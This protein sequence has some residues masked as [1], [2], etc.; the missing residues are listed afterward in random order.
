MRLIHLAAFASLAALAA[1]SDAPVTQSEARDPFDMSQVKLL[2]P[3]QYA[4]HGIAT[5]PASQSPSFLIDGPCQVDDPTSCGGGGEP[6][7]PPEADV[8]FWGGVF[9]ESNYAGKQVRLHAKSDAHNNMD[10][11]VLS[12]SFRSVGGQYGCS[13]TPA[14]FTSDYKV[15]YGAP[16]HVESERY[17]SYASSMTFIW[18]VKSSHSFTAN[19]GYVLPN[20]RRSY[21]FGSGGRLCV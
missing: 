12:V 14:Q 17:A 6:Y 16:V 8:D 2:T 21:T 18:E 7:T 5:L 1:C 15:A 10:Q 11:T 19:V 4:A 3:D 20:G 13:A 9:N